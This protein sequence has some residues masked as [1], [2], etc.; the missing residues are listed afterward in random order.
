MKMK[1]ILEYQGKQYIGK[2]SADFSDE[3]TKELIEA[4]YEN[5]GSINRYKMELED[6]S[7]LILG[8]DAIQS[9]VIKII[10]SNKETKNEP[11]TS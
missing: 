8:K 6:G 3:D 5:M 2:E 10:P 4:I 9:S 7:I 11:S 1:V